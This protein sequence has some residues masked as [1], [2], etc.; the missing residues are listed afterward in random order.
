VI[1]G[2]ETAEQVQMLVA[3]GIEVI[4]GFYF[5]QPLPVAT[6]WELSVSNTINSED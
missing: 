4:Q 6:A 3:L 5:Y 2:V 1:E